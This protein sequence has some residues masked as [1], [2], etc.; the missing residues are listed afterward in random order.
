MYGVP[1]DLDLSPFVGWQL[2]QICIGPYDLQFHVSGRGSISCYGE[3]RVQLDGETYR[4]F[5]K[6]GWRDVSSFPKI[7][8]RD[9]TAWSRDSIHEFSLALTGSAII[10]FRSEDEA[11]EDFTVGVRD[12]LWVI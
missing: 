6:D 8:G 3:V 7:V 4:V 1:E 9:V 5:G 10:R 11:Y 2:N 12:K